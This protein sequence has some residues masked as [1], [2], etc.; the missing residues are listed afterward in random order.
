MPATHPR[1]PCPPGL[2]RRPSPRSGCGWVGRGLVL[3]LLS[4]VVHGA[5][6]A[7]DTSLSW[8]SLTAAQQQALAPLKGE[9]ASIDRPRRQ[10]WLEVAARFPSMPLEEQARVRERMAAWATLTPGERAKARLQFTEAR[11][12][13]PDERLE[14]WQAYQALPPEERGR[15]AQSARPAASSVAPATARRDGGDPAPPARPRPVAPTVVQA[16]PGASTTTMTTPVRPPPHHQAGLPKIV[17][18]PGFVDPA[19]LL[20]MRGPQGA[21]A[22]PAASQP[23]AA[24]P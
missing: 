6:I 2:R 19:T 23:A 11:Q 22:T 4:L 9:W 24:Q 14:R 20:P 10:K 5:S 21:A 12:L 3:V 13:A 8:A 7:V 16:R 15:L 1:P 18:T 17:A